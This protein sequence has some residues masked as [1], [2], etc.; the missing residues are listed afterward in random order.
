M[1]LGVDAGIAAGPIGRTG[2]A[3][4]NLNLESAIYSYSRSKGVFAGV[5][6]DGAVL[7]IDNS[8]NSK[9]Y[10]PSVDA[11]QIVSGQVAVNSTVRPFVDTLNK[12]VPPK[13]LTQK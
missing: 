13:R 1:K 9:V 11:K 7:D 2:E 8:M 5:A 12:V 4:V 10:G 3:G 6:L